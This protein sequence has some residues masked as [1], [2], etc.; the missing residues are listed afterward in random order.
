[1]QLH[2][3]NANQVPQGT[4]TFTRY[5]VCLAR[6]LRSSVG[7]SKL[8]LLLESPSW[9]H[10]APQECHARLAMKAM[11]SGWVGVPD[12]HDTRI[13]IPR[14]VHG[15]LSHV[16]H[17]NAFTVPAWRPKSRSCPAPREHRLPYYLMVCTWSGRQRCRRLHS[18]AP[19]QALHSGPFTARSSRR[20]YWRRCRRSLPRRL[21]LCPPLPRRQQR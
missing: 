21:H 2:T 9:P 15:T 10:G 13:P 18:P 5:H 3:A 11:S 7:W 12:K 16:V 20:P 1:M 6:L 17:P 4:S 8:C 14:S 19:Q